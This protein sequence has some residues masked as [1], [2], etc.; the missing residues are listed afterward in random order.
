MQTECLDHLIEVHLAAPHCEPGLSNHG[1]DV[2]GVDRAIELAGLAG[3]ANHNNRQAIHAL[4]NGFGLL[5]R[6]KIIGFQLDT[7][8][9]EAF[10][11]LG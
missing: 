2:A 1:G 4:G 3:L 7:L 9:L 11:V 5:A 8:Y 10:S 6:L